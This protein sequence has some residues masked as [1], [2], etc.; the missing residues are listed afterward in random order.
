M[1]TNH[2]LAQADL[3]RS[4]FAGGG[5]HGDSDFKKTC[6]L[7]MEKKRYATKDDENNNKNKNVNDSYFATCDS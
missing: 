1:I 4:G 3:C 5:D 2:L 7:V 6:E